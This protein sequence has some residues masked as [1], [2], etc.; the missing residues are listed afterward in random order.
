MRDLSVDT[1]QEDNKNSR[2]ISGFCP[3]LRAQ[4]LIHAASAV[5]IMILAQH[6]SN[7]SI[8]IIPCV[9]SNIPV[10][11]YPLYRVSVSGNRTI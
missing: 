7:I 4:T 10:G 3:T 6:L 8:K 11:R 5:L 1:L 9:V 2:L